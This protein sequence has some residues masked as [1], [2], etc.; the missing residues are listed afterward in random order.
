MIGGPVNMY[1]GVHHMWDIEDVAGDAGFEERYLGGT[2]PRLADCHRQ[3]VAPFYDRVERQ[4]NANRDM[5]PED[6][7]THFLQWLLAQRA[8]YAIAEY[9]VDTEERK[10]RSAQAAAELGLLIG[11]GQPTTPSRSVKDKKNK[12]KKLMKQRKRKHAHQPPEQPQQ[13]ID[14]RMIPLMREA[15]LKPVRPGDFAQVAGR[16]WSD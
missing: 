9:V 12:R 5:Y 10:A 4:F 8:S 16:E 1:C 15:L 14:P 2:V 7:H 13:T 11:R 3:V 6:Q